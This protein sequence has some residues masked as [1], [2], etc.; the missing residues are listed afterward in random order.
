MSTNYVLLIALLFTF[1]AC[2]T[3]EPKDELTLME[4]SFYQQPDKEKGQALVAAFETKLD[5]MQGEPSEKINLLSKTATVYFRMGANEGLQANFARLLNEFKDQ[6]IATKATQ[7]ILDTLLHSITDPTT[8]RLV[9]NVAK[10]YIALTELYAKAKPDAPESPEQLYKAGEIARSIGAYQQAL[11]IYATIEGYFPQYEKAPKAL[12]MQGFTYAED[13]GDEEK[14]RELYEAFIAK[15]PNDDFV[16][17]AQ[18]LLETLG[19]TDEEIFQQ[20]ENQ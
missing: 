20:L 15:Y 4:E 9:P 12:F 7:N 13:L 17:D 19:K 6:P 14:A 18:I 11:G 8:Q 16:D 3:P 2:S 5:T 10:Q 1:F